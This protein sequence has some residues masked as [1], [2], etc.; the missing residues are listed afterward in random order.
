MRDV[1]KALDIVWHNGLTYKI[2]NLHLL[3]IIT[4]IL[5]NYIDNR[6]ASISL[7]HYE[8]PSFPI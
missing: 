3:P 7:P 6:T 2:Y 4:K 8:G 5:C 1:S